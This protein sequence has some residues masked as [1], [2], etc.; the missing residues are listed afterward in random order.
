MKDNNSPDNNEIQNLIKELKDMKKKSHSKLDEI[1]EDLDFIASPG[2]KLNLLPK[3]F[4]V[5]DNLPRDINKE[6]KLSTEQY[7]FSSETSKNLKKS[8]DAK[9]T[10]FNIDRLLPELDF[11]GENIS[12][13]RKSI[14]VVNN[15]VKE[16]FAEE[17]EIA[18][19]SWDQLLASSTEKFKTPTKD[20]RELD[21]EEII[22]NFSTFEIQESN[23]EISD[24]NFFSTADSESYFPKFAEY[25]EDIPISSPLY[26]LLIGFEDLKAYNINI[27]KW[28]KIIIE[29]EEE[30]IYLLNKRK[31]TGLKE[32][33]EES[34]EES[35]E[36]TLS[37]LEELKIIIEEIITEK[38]VV[39]SL[40]EP[41][42]RDI[43]LE[44]D[45]KELIDELKELN[46][47]LNDITEKVS[48]YQE[49][50]KNVDFNTP[51]EFIE[52][53]G[54][55]EFKTPNYLHL[56]RLAFSLMKREI[57]PELFSGALNKVWEILEEINEKYNTLQIKDDEVTKEVF[58]ANKIIYE[59]LE[60]WQ[61]GILLLEDYLNSEDEKNVHDG[62]KM[63]CEGNKKLIYIQYFEKKIK[64]QVELE[65]FQANFPR[66]NW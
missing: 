65:K 6:Y 17:K 33:E 16:V 40:T 60:N 27:K 3:E 26:N 20:T 66:V 25:S 29:T 64:K 18:I 37:I 51:E 42:K 21:E 10:R 19:D 47:K 30:L 48:L 41:A 15:S 12:R 8:V 58:T 2:Q 24:E 56:E 5:E 57:S 62:L 63:I 32:D 59:A 14:E 53:L 9:K 54:E 44:T 23:R 11:P 38:K 34:F 46:I 28:E 35:L 1:K 61:Q 43:T 50:S 31:K 7:Q 45:I 13:I 22:T 36:Q 4:K 55:E 39:F 49:D 52:S